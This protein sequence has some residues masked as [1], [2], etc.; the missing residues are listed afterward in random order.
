MSA[1]RRGSEEFDSVATGGV[2]ER[3]GIDRA[4]V[5]QAKLRGRPAD[6]TGEGLEP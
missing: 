1:L 4:R 5:G 6:L 3:G 2:T